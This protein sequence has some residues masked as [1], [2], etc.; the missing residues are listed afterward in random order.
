MLKQT[1]FIQ[2][3]YVSILFSIYWDKHEY[4]IKHNFSKWDSFSSINKKQFH[5]ILC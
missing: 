5:N 1:Y 2:R 3:I 4:E